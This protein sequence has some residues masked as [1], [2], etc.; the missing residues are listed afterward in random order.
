MPHATIT[1][2]NSILFHATFLPG[3]LSNHI[4]LRKITNAFE[5]FVHQSIE[6][7]IQS[8]CHALVQKLDIENDEILFLI[9]SKYF[10]EN[11]GVSE[12]MKNSINQ[13]A[14]TFIGIHQ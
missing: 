5:Q 7:N 13:A 6:K 1:T 4:S 12:L 9:K 3:T 2:D 10:Q 8:Q 14:G 11:P